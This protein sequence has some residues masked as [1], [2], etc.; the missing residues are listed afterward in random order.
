VRA[1]EPDRVGTVVRHGVEIAF[2]IFGDEHDASVLLLPAWSIVHSRLWKAQVPV[3]AGRYRVITFDG[4]GNGGSGRPSGADAYLPDEYVAFSTRRASN[5]PPSRVSPS[6]ATSHCC[7]Q[8]G[9]PNGWRGRVSLARPCPSPRRDCHPACSPT[10]RSTR[11]PTRAGNNTTATRGSATTRDSWSS[12]SRS[13]SPNPT[14]PSHERIASPGA[15]DDPRGP[16]RHRRRARRHRPA[17]G[18]GHR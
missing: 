4:R 14:R 1:R 9:T 8:H 7:L 11:T 16:G 18:W 5:V 15:R 13:A 2:E 12:S 17:A 6:A 3:L 10:L